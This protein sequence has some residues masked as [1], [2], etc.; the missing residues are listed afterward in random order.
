MLWQKDYTS[1]PIYQS[2]LQFGD[3]EL[4]FQLLRTEDS[5]SEFD[6]FFVHIENLI[7]KD[8]VYANNDIDRLSIVYQFL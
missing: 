1:T 4:D 6:V 5:V 3:Q 2:N 8:Y 7:Y